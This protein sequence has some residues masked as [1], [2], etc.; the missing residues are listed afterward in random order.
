MPNNLEKPITSEIEL[1][2]DLVHVEGASFQ[3]GSDNGPDSEKP[4]HEVTLSDFYISQYPITVKQY[5][6]FCDETGK[7]MPKKPSWGWRS[8]HPIVNVSWEE[9]KAYCEWKNGRLPTE[10]EW[11]FSAI[12]GK[13]K[14]VYE[15]SGSNQAKDVAWYEKNARSQTYMVGKKTANELNLFDMSG[16]VWEWCIDRYASYNG[17]PQN[18]PQGPTEGNKRVLRGGSWNCGDYRLRITVR[19]G[20]DSKYKHSDVGFRLVKS[21]EVVRTLL[22]EK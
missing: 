9:A 19:R 4:V 1:P 22:L 18:N 14:R 10:A 21:K 17:E 11:E 5:R 16:N 6:L 7:P 13:K 20:I 8:D 2:D 15:Y 12:G 3:M